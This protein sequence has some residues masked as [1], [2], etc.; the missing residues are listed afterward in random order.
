MKVLFV[1]ITLFLLIKLPTPISSIGYG[2]S[3]GQSPWGGTEGGDGAVC[4]YISKYGIPMNL[5]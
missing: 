1:I 5:R 4:N 3:V 2:F